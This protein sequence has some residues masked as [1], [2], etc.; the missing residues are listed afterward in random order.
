[1][2][3]CMGF[4]FAIFMAV[5]GTPLFAMDLS[6]DE[7][8]SKI[9][10]ESQDMKKADANIKKAE[11]S[12]DAAN[13]NR[14]FKLEGSASYMNMV[15]VKEPFSS[16]AKVTLPPQLGG[17]IGQ[18]INNGNP[19]SEIEMPDNIF[20]AGLTF[21]QPIYTFGKIGNAVDSVRSAIKMSET[22]KE[23]V[24]REV[25]YSA[26][27][28]YWT[29]KMA[30][31][32]VKLSEQDLKSAQN[33]RRNLTSAGR[34]NRGN[35]VKIESDIATKEINLSDAKFNRDTAY[36][37]LKILAGIDVDEELN[38]TTDFPKQFANLD[39]KKLSNTPEWDLLNQQ[40]RMYE[41]S[42]RSKRA[43][44]LPTLAA[45]ASY[46]YSSM[47]R[48]ADELFDKEGQQSAYWGLAFQMPIFSGGVN[49][50]NATIEAMNAEAVRQD[51]DKSKKI[52][53]EKYNTA[54]Q[55]YNHLRGNLA[56]LQNA[57]DLAARAYSFS[58]QRFIAGQ[59]S[60]I[61]LAEVSSGLYQ[62]DMAL[63]N[64]KYKILM[65]A[66]SVKKLGE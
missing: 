51:L 20:T 1:M 18:Y 19:V 6:L 33:A 66:E 48:A 22:N 63:L 49:S 37:M 64:S 54:I 44:A 26:V 9:L 35:L 16:S 7:A 38:L 31:E 55:Q 24:M 61:E 4:F 53:T 41:K 52:T 17:I 21:T 43:G 8:V 2:R 39:A 45:T 36:R 40:I 12:L 5:F 23:M 25:R 15:D 47:G 65:A 56:T 32:I 57:R 59:T 50:A 3:K 29:A 27:D 11:A 28:L 10:A 34:A 46:S 13:A 42:A 62:L 14:W 58:Q 60:A 30:D